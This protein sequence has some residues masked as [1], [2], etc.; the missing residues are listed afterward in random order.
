M[1]TDR[2]D[3]TVSSITQSKATHYFYNTSNEPVEADED[4]GDVARL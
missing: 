4:R 2:G 3:I 1:D